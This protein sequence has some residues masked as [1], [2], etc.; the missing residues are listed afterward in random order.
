MADVSVVLDKSGNAVQFRNPATHPL[1]PGAG[2]TIVQTKD[3]SGKSPLPAVKFPV[4]PL[5]ITIL[6]EASALAATAQHNFAEKENSNGNRSNIYVW[7]Y[8][9]DR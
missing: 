7:K 3:T 9:R 1:P 2:Q 8:G 6:L 4:E 5:S